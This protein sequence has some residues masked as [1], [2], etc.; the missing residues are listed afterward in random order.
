MSKGMTEEKGGAKRLVLDLGAQSW[1][2]IKDKALR[3][4]KGRKRRGCWGLPAQQIWGKE[5][6]VMALS[7]KVKSWCY[8]PREE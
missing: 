2:K 7:I 5:G 1:L 6:Q 4:G 3:A 8:G